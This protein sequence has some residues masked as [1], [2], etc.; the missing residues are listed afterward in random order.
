MA[1]ETPLQCITR[2]LKEETGLSCDRFTEV[3]QAIGE[4]GHSLFHCY[5]CTVDCD[6]LSV[7]LQK[8]ETVDFCWMSK[9]EFIRFLHSD[10]VIPTQKARYLSYFRQ[11]GYIK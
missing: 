7:Q 8:G 11:I 6:K 5:I 1:G 10:N 2:E 3:A 9:D 4:I